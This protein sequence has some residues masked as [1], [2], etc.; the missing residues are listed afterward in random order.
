[1]NKV[2]PSGSLATLMTLGAAPVLWVSQVNLRCEKIKSALLG[3]PAC[4]AGCRRPQ[5]RISGTYDEVKVGIPALVV[6]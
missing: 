1:M 4:E 6:G 2:K 3:S 5:N